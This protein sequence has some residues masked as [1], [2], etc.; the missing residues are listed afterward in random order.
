MPQGGA[1][2]QNLGSLEYVYTFKKEP[3][4]GVYLPFRTLCLVFF[5]EATKIILQIAFG[6]VCFFVYYPGQ[7]FFSLVGTELDGMFPSVFR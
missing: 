5:G 6:L 4:L 3:H 7:Q 1:S 2:G